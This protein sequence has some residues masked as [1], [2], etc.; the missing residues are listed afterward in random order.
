MLHLRPECQLYQL[1]LGEG[2]YIL[3]GHPVVATS[4]EEGRVPDV[5]GHPWVE[6]VVNHHCQFRQSTSAL[7]TRQPPEELT[8]DEFHVLRPH[9]RHPGMDEVNRRHG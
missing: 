8:K 9:H 2:R 4:R 7:Q 5:W 3:H 6:E 1:H